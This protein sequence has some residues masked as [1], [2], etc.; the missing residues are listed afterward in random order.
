MLNADTKNIG[1]ISFINRDL[2]IAK[3]L[4]NAKIYDV[5]Q[6]GYGRKIGEI[7]DKNNDEIYIQTYENI[8]SVIQSDPVYSTGKNFLA[9][10]S[11]DIFNQHNKNVAEKKWNFLPMVFKG[12]EVMTGDILGEI[13]ISPAIS[14]KILA[15][16]NSGGKIMSIK[17]GSFNTEETIAHVETSRGVIDISARQTWPIRIP[18]PYQEKILQEPELIS[19]QNVFE[20]IFSSK[21]SNPAE[22]SIIQR[23]FAK[24]TEADIII[25]VLRNKDS[26]GCINKFSEFKDIKT[27]RPL[28]E[29]T[30]FFANDGKFPSSRDLFMD[31]T[32]TAAEYFRDM[33]YNVLL[34][35]DAIS[36][37]K[38][39]LA[40]LENFCQ[41]KTDYYSMRLQNFFGKAGR[42][43]CLGH[44]E[45]IGSVAIIGGEE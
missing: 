20:S 21:S 44:D 31:K 45:R 1:K 11:P 27:K 25:I 29:K 17:S 15:P 3:N 23:Q 24:W 18:R 22:K 2:I 12:S 8:P 36:G 40:E 16:H 10:F 32:I 38:K 13:K 37:W 41:N 14:Y 42:V 35:I 4:E 39:D 30:I 5:V 33:G 6:I 19:K 9:K 34:I 26:R 28:L 43:K 7:I